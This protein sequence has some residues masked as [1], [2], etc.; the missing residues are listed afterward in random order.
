MQ[1]GVRADARRAGTA[2]QAAVDMRVLLSI[3]LG[4][5]R[6]ARPRKAAAV[7]DVR[8]R[9]RVSRRDAPTQ[10]ARSAARVCVL[11]WQLRAAASRAAL[12]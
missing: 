7:A 11:T 12:C 3:T 6:L 10:Q 9:R 8:R 1:L 2:A 4:R 5:R